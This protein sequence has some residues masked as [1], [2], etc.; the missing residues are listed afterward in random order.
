MKQQKQGNI[1]LKSSFM[2]LISIE[3]SLLKWLFRI[4]DSGYFPN[5]GHSCIQSLCWLIYDLQVV[6][7]CDILDENQRLGNI[8]PFGDE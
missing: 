6:T 8:Q 2:L 3:E 7:V 4:L 1:E 5:S